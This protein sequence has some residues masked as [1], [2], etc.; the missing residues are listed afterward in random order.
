MA[1]AFAAAA[2]AWPPLLTLLVAVVL[3]AVPAAVRAAEAEYSAVPLGAPM[4]YKVV[5]GHVGAAACW[6]RFDGDGMSK[7]GFDTLS[8]ESNGALPDEQQAAA[9][10]FLEGFVTQKRIWQA[11][12]AH[13]S[14][15]SSH[16]RAWLAMNA[17]WMAEMVAKNP[18]S[19]FWQHVR[20]VDVQMLGLW[21]GYVAAG[22]PPAEQ[23]PF[24]AF[25]AMSFDDDL[26]TIDQTR[27]PPAFGRMDGGQLLQHMVVRE[28]CSALVRLLPDRSDVVVAHNTWGGYQNM[29]RVVKAYTLHFA[30]A[31]ATS[32]VFPGYYGSL[33]SGDDTYVTEGSRLTVLETTN[34]ICNEAL[35]ARLTPKSVLYV[36][37]ALV[38]TRL[39]RTA[40]EWVLRFETYQ[41]GTYN[42]QWMVVDNKLFVPGRE[43]PPGTLAVLEL[44]PGA[45][46]HTDATDVLNRD[47]YWA[48]FNRPYFPSM[49]QLLGFA[50][51]TARFGDLFSHDHNPRANIFRRDTPATASV[52]DVRALIMSNAYKTDPLALGFPGNTIG[53]RFDFLGGPLNNTPYD[54]WFVKGLHG[55]RDGKVFSVA[56]STTAAAVGATLYAV[57]GPPYNDQCPPFEFS[58]EYADVPH[59]GVP[60][61]MQFSWYRF[62]HHATTN[63]FTCSKVT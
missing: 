51:A 58:G 19:L 43:A 20:L 1:A 26:D 53:G 2:R 63:S 57:N 35:F 22:P 12:S 50:N 21:R 52:A 24:E 15:L 36:Y 3:A 40:S 6:T 42:N 5:A 56:E 39:A 37:R 34:S 14:T 25:Q 27:C 47:G 48:S 29:L 7:T 31:Q 62:Q 18:G 60:T 45:T 55:A 38:A 13:N 54:S 9:C 10:G 32:V 17:Q 49:F 30:A 44:A 28:H 46:E 4:Q 8:I 41:S 61:R 23:L 16:A 33:H 59:P 11:Y